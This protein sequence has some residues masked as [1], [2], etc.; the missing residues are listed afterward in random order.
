MAE[1]HK[2]GKDGILRDGVS[3][4]PA[5]AH[6]MQ[7]YVDAQQQL[8]QLK[9][10]IFVHAD[11]PHEKLFVACFDGTGNDANN[12]PE[13]ATGVARIH[14][15]IQALNK[16]GQTQVV[17]GYVEGPGTQRNL[18]IKAWD[19]ARGHTYDERLEKMYQQLIEQ[20]KRWRNED[21]NAQIRI[22]EIGFSRGAEQA[23][24]FT[25]MVQEL[26]IQDPSGRVQDSQGRITYTKPP[27][28][29][30]GKVAQFPA[31][32]D[33]V[34]TGEPIEKHDRRLPSSAIARFQVTAEDEGRRQF[35]VSPIV[36]PGLSDDRFSLNVMV[37]G[38][39][40]NI[41]DTYHHNG[42]GIRNT[43]MVVDVLNGLS[44]QPFL[45]KRAE[46]DDPR[47]NVVHRSENGLFWLYR[48]TPLV[49]RRTPDGVN[50]R[51][52]P[53]ELEGKVA[54]A[55]R[56]ETIDQEL[57]AQFE[58]RAVKIGPV[59]SAQPAHAAQSAANDPAILVDRFLSAAASSD[60]LAFRDA[61]RTA[62]N[63]D[64]AR[65]L[66]EYAVTTVDQQQA[67]AQQQATQQQDAQQHEAPAR[68]LAVPMH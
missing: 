4:Y 13:H 12:D 31:L 55:Y 1:K 53:E 24:G 68:R 67:A 17:P 50:A 54:D 57:A 16:S 11:K 65:A 56:S 35:K 26:G 10:P 32:L 28:V 15:Q 36:E 21:P 8:S 14:E 20:A 41:G 33:P 29:P 25:R 58:F 62:A 59:P 27:L 39:H 64:A 2:V 22:A 66:R 37:G 52:V 7:T 30:P 63:H 47:L 48:L 51:L 34:G 61:T 9:V 19:G 60:N 3:F 23:A 6:D 44:D 40:S 5:D 42:L 49:D 45:E 18:L 43:N 46:P 38:K